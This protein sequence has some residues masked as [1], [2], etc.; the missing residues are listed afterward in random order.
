MH[1]RC[2][3]LC[4]SAARLGLR[5]CVW[6]EGHPDVR[7]V[8]YRCLGEGARGPFAAGRLCTTPTTPQSPVPNASLERHRVSRLGGGAAE[9]VVA[10]AGGDDAVGTVLALS[11]SGAAAARAPERRFARGGGQAGAVAAPVNCVGPVRANTVNAAIDGR[12]P[13]CLVV[14]VR[15]VGPTRVCNNLVVDGFGD[16]VGVNDLPIAVAGIEPGADDACCV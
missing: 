12:E 1:D 4:G 5:A 9:G 16:G 15:L 14:S 6:L 2:C 8:V 3:R 13:A 7:L 11:C 10:V